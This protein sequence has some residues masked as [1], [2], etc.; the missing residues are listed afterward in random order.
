MCTEKEV[1]MFNLWT[2]SMQSLNNK[3]WKMF[4]L[5]ITQTRHHVSILNRNISMLKA[6]K[7]KCA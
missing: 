4:E 1:H 2:M 5:H 6:P 3:E 7:I